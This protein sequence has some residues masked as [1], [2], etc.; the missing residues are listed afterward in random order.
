MLVELASIVHLPQAIDCGG[1]LTEVLLDKNVF[2]SV[3]KLEWVL[4]CYK[5]TGTWVRYGIWSFTSLQIPYTQSSTLPIL[6]HSF[7]G[8]AALQPEL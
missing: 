5:T 2:I 7:Y 8:D 3:P 4:F 1:D 6:S